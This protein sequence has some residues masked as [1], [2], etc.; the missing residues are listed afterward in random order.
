M[1]ASHIIQKEIERIGSMVMITDG[2]WSSV[3]FKAIISPL[4][5]K[6]S[7]N[8]EKKLTVL[9]GSIMEYYQYIGG[10]NH[11]VTDLT[12]NA[13]L[14]FNGDKYEFKHRDKII[15]ENRVLYYTG[16]LRKLNGDDN[17]EYGKSN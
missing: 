11:A 12:E 4:W 3:P 6:K 7:S 10:A 16:I 9:G 5:R 14:I 2:E 15:A 13:L 1:N 17:D 8:F